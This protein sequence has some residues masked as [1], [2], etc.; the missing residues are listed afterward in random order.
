MKTE[1][2][3]QQLTRAPSSWKPGGLI[4]NNTKCPDPG[5]PTQPTKPPAPCVSWKYKCDPADIKLEPITTFCKDLRQKTETRII[6]VYSIIDSNN[7][8]IDTETD[9]AIH[10]VYKFFNDEKNKNKP[11]HY[12]IQYPEGTFYFNYRLQMNKS[13]SFLEKITQKMAN[14]DFGNQFFS[15]SND[16]KKIQ[17]LT[18]MGKGSENTIFVTTDSNI[19]AINGSGITGKIMFKG[20]TFSRDHLSS[21]QGKITNNDFNDTTSRSDLTIKIEQG[22]PS[23]KELLERKEETI[24]HIESSKIIND[25]NCKQLSIKL[26]TGKGFKQGNFIHKYNPD[27]IKDK[28]S[29]GQAKIFNVEDLLNSNS[30]KVI[31]KVAAENKKSW[32]KGD[33][34]AIKIKSGGFPYYLWGENGKLLFV[35]I[36]WTH[37]TRGIIRGRWDRVYMDRIHIPNTSVNNIRP[38]IASSGGGPQIGGETDGY[39]CDFVKHFTLTNSTI[40]NSGDD[41]LGLFHIQN[42]EINNIVTSNAFGRNI[43]FHQ[44]PN[45]LL[46]NITTD[47]EGRFEY[48]FKNK[49]GL[50]EL[51]NPWDRQNKDGKYTCMNEVLENVPERK[52]KNYSRNPTTDIVK[53]EIHIPLNPAIAPTN[54]QWKLF[55]NIVNQAKDEHNT[56]TGKIQQKF[57]EK[58]NNHYKK[59]RKIINLKIKVCN[60]KPEYSYCNHLRKDKLINQCDLPGQKEYCP[61]TCGGVCSNSGN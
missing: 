59:T 38:Y 41:N 31:I 6:K 52:K 48:N 26:Y 21:S 1:R 33:N 25:S 53:N 3:Q 11:I 44:T 13:L 45:C 17:K 61:G 14:F 12:I 30:D 56:K 23:I 34:I 20:I 24:K 54:V 29:M 37:K 18:I 10:T 28:K 2:F 49:K 27:G 40:M 42:C 22:F 5:I 36:K 9:K 8:D 47:L 15:V 39:K 57:Y 19:H 7:I 35:D 58:H 43:L 50:N 60:G 4:N 55:T 32:K 16:C 51:L 46:S